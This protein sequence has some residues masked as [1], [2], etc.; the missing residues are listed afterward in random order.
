MRRLLGSL[1][2]L[3]FVSPSKIPILGGFCKVYFL[4]S[5]NFH[6]TNFMCVYCLNCAIMVHCE[7]GI[8]SGLEGAQKATA[9]SQRKHKGEEAKA[10]ALALTDE[11]NPGKRGNVHGRASASTKRQKGTKQVSTDGIVTEARLVCRSSP[12]EHYLMGRFDGSTQLRR[13]IGCTAVM[14]PNYA[15]IVERINEAINKGGMTKSAAV[16]MRADLLAEQPT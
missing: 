9:L 8:S 5:N 12:K 7:C 11:A 4:T 10:A 13:V 6:I 3:S 2:T 14:S 1:Q 15:S 16:N